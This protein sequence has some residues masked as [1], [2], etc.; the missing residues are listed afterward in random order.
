M[1]MKYLVL[2]TLMLTTITDLNFCIH[3]HTHTQYSFLIWI[4]LSL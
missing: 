2:S 3:T 1:I 4:L